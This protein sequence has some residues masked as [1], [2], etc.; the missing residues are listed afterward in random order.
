MEDNMKLGFQERSNAQKREAKRLRR[1][2][3]VPAVLYSDGK[4]GRSI[5]VDSTEFQTALRQVKKGHLATTVF[6]L[7][8]N[9]KAHRAIV[10]DIQYHPTTYAVLHLDFEEL[11]SDVY[12]NVKVPIECTGVVDCQGI[13]LGGVLR[14]VIR[15]LKIRCLPK[16]MPASFP[17]N[18]ADMGIKDS[19]RLKDLD[20]PANVRPLADLNEVA[21]AIVKR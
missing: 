7:S 9:G 12:V 4:E 14:Q 20:L 6:E 5:A 18:I 10:K 15:A 17:V 16:D 8:D 3:K 13:K 1:G 21:V 19:L 11:H 2:G